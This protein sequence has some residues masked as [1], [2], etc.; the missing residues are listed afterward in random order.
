VKKKLIFKESDFFKIFKVNFDNVCN[1][2]T[3]NMICQFPSCGICQ[4]ED[5]EIPL[6]WKQAESELE[7]VDKKMDDFFYKW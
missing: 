7:I 6:P 5:H 4:C 2:H 3:Q 1:F